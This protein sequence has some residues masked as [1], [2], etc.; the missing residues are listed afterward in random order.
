MK[1]DGGHNAHSESNR[2]PVAGVRPSTRADQY[3]GGCH[4]ELESIYDHALNIRLEVPLA[5]HLPVNWN[6][7]I[8]CPMRKMKFEL[9]RPFRVKMR[10]TRPE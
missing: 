3:K 8:E 9:A 10:N 6:V 1:D 2:R 4:G 5:H 7:P